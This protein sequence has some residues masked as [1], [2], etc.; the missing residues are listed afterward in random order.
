VEELIVYPVDLAPFHDGPEGK[1]AVA[2]AVDAACRA[3]GFLVLTGHG[4]APAVIDTWVSV[5]SEFFA[6]PLAEKRRYRVSDPT[7]NRG[8]TE[9]GIEGLAYTLGD[10]T[11]PDLFEAMTFGREDAVGPHFEERRH[12]FRPNIW[13]DEP[14]GMRAAFLAYDAAIRGVEDVVLRAMAIALDLPEAWLADECAGSV[15]TTR[16]IRYERAPEAPEPE[17]GQMRLGAHTDY[18][19]LTVLWADDVPGLQVRRHDRW[20]DVS[21]APGTLLANI[22]DMLARWTNDRWRSTLHRVTPPPSRTSGPAQRRSVARFVDGDP[23]R[24]IEC[25]PSCCTAGNPARYAPIN[26]GEWLQAKVV[27][28]K[29]LSV[30]PGEVVRK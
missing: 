19:V 1:A 23:S 12:Y 2:A 5:C 4:V 22:G 13:P 9:P 30:V 6:R 15:L 11:P 10:A 3:T 18:G 20:H 24:T 8:Y 16:A 25:I 27:G 14:A 26:A 21:V 17:A 29:T 28:G 7:A